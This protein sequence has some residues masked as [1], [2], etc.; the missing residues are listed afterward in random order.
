MGLVREDPGTKRRECPD[1]TDDEEHRDHP[2]PPS[3]QGVGGTAAISLSLLLPDAQEHHDI[4]ALAT[5]VTI[6]MERGTYQLEIP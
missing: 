4:V 1:I 3:T 5:N 6:F 2:Q